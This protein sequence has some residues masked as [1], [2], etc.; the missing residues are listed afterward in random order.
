MWV[1]GVELNET[2]NWSGLIAAAEQGD[3]E[4]E[5]G[6]ASNCARACEHLIDQLTRI[7]DGTRGLAKIDGL[8]PL[9]SGV[10]LASKFGR[11][12]TGGDYSLDHAIADHIRVVGDMRDVFQK[13]ETR[14]AAAEEANTAAASAVESQL[15]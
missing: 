7:L 14:Y 3:L 11:K 2:G 6:T 13:I 8:G 5:R 12:A 1:G 10:A 15:N 9:P 4:L